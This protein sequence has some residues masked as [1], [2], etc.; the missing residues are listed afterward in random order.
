MPAPIVFPS[1][2]P[3]PIASSISCNKTV[4]KSY[5]YNTYKYQSKFYDQHIYCVYS[6]FVGFMYVRFRLHIPILTEI[7]ES[8]ATL[9]TW[10]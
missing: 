5:L 7:V 1:P 3:K 4:N 8:C 6:Y 2:E 9:F 10:E